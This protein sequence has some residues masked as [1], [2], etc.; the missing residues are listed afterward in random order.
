MNGSLDIP[1]DRH[2]IPMILF[3]HGNGSCGRTKLYRGVS[4]NSNIPAKLDRMADA[5]LILIEDS[6]SNTS[7]LS[8]TETG[9]GVAE[10]LKEIEM[11]LS[12]Q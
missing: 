11:V 12:E 2:V 3:L 7:E 5:G 6:G 8:L 10:I 9:R 4:R 1:C